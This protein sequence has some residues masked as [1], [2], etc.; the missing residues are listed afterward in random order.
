[1]TE[2]RIKENAT[3]KVEGLGLV[4]VLSAVVGS[5]L[6]TAL[7]YP[8]FY[9]GDWSRLW[10]QT[11]I[12]GGVFDGGFL[13]AV[14]ISH[15]NA[16]GTSAWLAGGRLR[17]TGSRA[18]SRTRTNWL[19]SRRLLGYTDV[20][21]IFNS[22]QAH[23]ITGVHFLRGDSRGYYSSAP[24]RLRR[25]VKNFCRSCVFATTTFLLALK[26]MCHIFKGE[27]HNDDSISDVQITS[28]AFSQRHSSSVC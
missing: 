4:I 15:I 27:F 6:L 26:C 18:S 7:D 11:T 12:R 1:M 20:G 22:A 2:F 13:L 14:I 25:P 24:V 10:D 17:R 3:H 19:L 21:E 16:T 9:S 8:G 28:A 5:N 23:A